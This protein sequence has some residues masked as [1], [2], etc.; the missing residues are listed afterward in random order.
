MI[1]DE[2]DHVGFDPRGASYSTSSTSSSTSSPHISP[3][4]LQ[5]ANTISL[6]YKTGIGETTP[7][8][9]QFT[10][11]IERQLL[12]IQQPSPLNISISNEDQGADESGLSR[13]LAYADLYAALS[14]ERTGTNMGVGK[15]VGTVTVA[16]DMLRITE[17]YHEG[18]EGDAK[19]RGV[20]F[21]GGSYGTVLGAT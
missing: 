15:F 7:S 9:T 18:R 21:S 1:G 16:R 6:P 8:Y 20:M 2:F 5:C 13:W 17:A 12:E 10:S 19:A 4:L 3:N 14:E 11:P